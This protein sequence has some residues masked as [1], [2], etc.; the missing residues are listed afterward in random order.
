MVVNV[1]PFQRIVGF[2]WPGGDIDPLSPM[3]ITSTATVSALGPNVH[4]GNPPVPWDGIAP[5]L[6][7]DWYPEYQYWS[8]LEVVW[9][10]WPA[11]YGSQYFRNANIFGPTGSLL[12]S[13]VATDLGVN[14]AKP[15]MPQVFPLGEWEYA[16]VGGVYLPPV[17]S[18]VENPIGT[19]YADGGIGYTNGA[20]FLASPEPTYYLGGDG[21][22][23]M[24][25]KFKIRELGFNYPVAPVDL[26]SLSA[27]Y[28]GNTYEAIGFQQSIYVVSQLIVTV[29]LK[30]VETSA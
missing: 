6:P 27:V 19:F 29:L 14:F 26:R 9:D 5:P 2:Y 28:E 7:G 1:G 12:A 17:S 30:R 11:W 16:E 21:G 13:G 18:P 15:T 20:R 3:Y 23:G 25:Q 10:E 24:M 22:I 8:I 4:P